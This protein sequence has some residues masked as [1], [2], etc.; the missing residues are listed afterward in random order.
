MA[1]VLKSRKFWA[2]LIGLLVSLGVM[3][4][5]DQQEAE[6]VA[7]ILVVVD[8][9]GY[10]ILTAWEDVAKRKVEVEMWRAGSPPHRGRS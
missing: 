2:A 10:Q 1:H 7:A 9:L 8:M 5:S 4:L 6:L 3:T